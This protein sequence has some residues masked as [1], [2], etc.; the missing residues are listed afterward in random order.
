M[1]VVLEVADQLPQL[2]PHLRR[3]ARPATPA[4]ASA[5]ATPRPLARRGSPWPRSA[6]RCAAASSSR[7][8]DLGEVAQVLGGVIPVQDRRQVLG[9]VTLQRL[10]QAVAAVGHRDQV[11]HLR[12]RPA[13]APATALAPPGRPVR[14]R[15]G[16]GCAPC[17]ACTARR[18]TACG[19]RPCPPRPLHRH[20]ERI[21]AHVGRRLAAF[22]RRRPLR[23]RCVGSTIR[24]SFCCAR[25][26]SPSPS[27]QRS[28]VEADSRTP[29]NRCSTSSAASANGSSVPARQTS[30]I[31]PGLISSTSPSA[32]S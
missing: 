3:R 24:P 8:P 17:P 16:S 5:S 20:A 11:A 31:S 6:T 14:N 18:C 1:A 32:S 26:R 28:T 19:A 22:P 27:V 13:P 9:Q 12:R 30:G 7:V 23:L 21:Q 2:L 10:L 4:P 15:P 25:N 29:A